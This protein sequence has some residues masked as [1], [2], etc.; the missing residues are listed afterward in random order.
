[1]PKQKKK[2]PGRPP[3]EG[4]RNVGK[5]IRVSDE[6]AEYLNEFGTGIVE[7]VIRKSK[8]FRAWKQLRLEQ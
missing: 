6:V 2:K 4:A 7:D 1:M 3:V 8:A 5:S